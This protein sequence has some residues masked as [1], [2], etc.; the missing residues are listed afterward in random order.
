[1]SKKIACVIPNYNESRFLIA[2]LKE[3][4]NQGFNEIIV[5]DDQSTD[6]SLQLLNRIDGIK[7]LCNP[8]KGAASAFMYGVYNTDCEYV[9]CW[10]CDD[11]S[12][13]Q[14]LNKI[15]ILMDKFPIVD[16]YTCN[17]IVLKEGNSYKKTLLPFDAYISPEYISKIFKAGHYGALNY[18]GAV[19]KKKVL[20]DC[21]ERGGELMPCNFDDM[22]SAYCMFTKGFINVADHLVI[23]NSYDTGLGNKGKMKA[24]IE[25]TEIKNSYLK[26]TFNDK[27]YE[28][29]EASGMSGTR[30]AIKS[31][32]ALAIV[33][34]L[35]YVLRKM[36]YKWYYGYNS[37]REKL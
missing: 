2:N 36:F 4:K 1:M 17:A 16:M 13:P 3:L 25:A 35:P 15:R 30:H 10:S 26:A 29:F 23:Y 28:L 32:L 5:V 12:R 22:Y 8:G 21:W 14:Y 34:L 31:R 24:T 37:R 19:Y 9:S 33:R 18:I 27:A 7:I 20:T 11:F 6:I